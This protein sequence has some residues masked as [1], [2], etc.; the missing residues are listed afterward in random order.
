METGC[1][2]L[3]LLYIAIIN[4]STRISLQ[5]MLR[6]MEH[7]LSPSSLV[8]TKQ[9]SLLQLD[10]MN[11]GPSMPRLATSIITLDVHMGTGSSLLGFYLSRKVYF[12]YHHETCHLMPVTFISWQDSNR[13]CW[14]PTVSA[15]VIPRLPVT[16]IGITSCWRN[17]AWNPSMSWWMLS[18]CDMGYWTVHSWLPGAGIFDMHCTRLVSTVRHPQPGIYDS[19]YSS[20]LHL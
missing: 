15:K 4:V 3:F 17:K 2:Y 1:K 10:T 11:I 5:R 18:T 20:L 9:Q 12:H 8:A 13:D 19:L 7:Y 16:C 6:C 14:V